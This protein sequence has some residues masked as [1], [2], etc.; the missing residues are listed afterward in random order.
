MRR[1]T[2]WRQEPSKV[3]LIQQANRMSDSTSRAIAAAVGAFWGLVLIGF[4]FWLSK[5]G[6]DGIGAALA[7]LAYSIGYF[8]F[9]WIVCH[10]RASFDQADRDREY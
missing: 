9:A 1:L 6:S 2:I 4:A 10:D 3:G 5:T 8:R 7:C